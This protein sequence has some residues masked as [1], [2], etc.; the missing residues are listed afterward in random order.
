MNTEESKP[1]KR[2]NILI[3]NLIFIVICAGLFMFLWNAPEETTK[4]LPNDDDHS[5]F[6]KMDKKEAEKFCEECHSPD[7]VSPLPQDHP[8]KYRCLF[9]HKRDQ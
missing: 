5:R 8:P 7:G 9:C 3:Y 1:A 4:H 6:M 2:K